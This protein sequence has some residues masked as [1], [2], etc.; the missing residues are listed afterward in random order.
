MATPAEQV[1][2]EYAMKSVVGES[3]YMYRLFD[4]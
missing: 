3:M 1:G 2:S 4:N